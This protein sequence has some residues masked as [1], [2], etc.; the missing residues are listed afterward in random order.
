MN[1]GQDKVD[2]RMPGIL[3]ICTANLF[4]SP[5]AALL[6]ASHLSRAGLS[7]EWHVES[8]G[9]TAMTDQPAASLAQL[10]MSEWGLDLSEHRSQPVSLALMQRCNLVLT[11]ER[12]Q[13]E[14]L[15]LQYPAHAQHIYL[16]SE[17][18]GFSYDIADPNH[19]S[20]DS[21][22]ATAREIDNLLKRGF[23]AIQQRAQQYA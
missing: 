5:I 10:V 16:L 12:R 2:Q 11:M 14:V 9:T 4:R 19:N 20:I 23:N 8:A 7:E 21:I 18:V 22:R 1:E 15:R 6:F 3:F 17:M 13:K